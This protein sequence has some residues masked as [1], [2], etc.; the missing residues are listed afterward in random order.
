[1][2]LLRFWFKHQMSHR[3][4]TRKEQDGC[5]AVKY[6]RLKGWIDRDDE[7]A[8]ERLGRNEASIQNAY[9]KKCGLKN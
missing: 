3:E 7:D 4:K 5:M 9:Y 2:C 8:A 1:M 6:G